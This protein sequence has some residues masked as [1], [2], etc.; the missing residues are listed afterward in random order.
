MTSKQYITIVLVIV[1]L[2]I[3]A[4]ACKKVEVIEPELQP[5]EQ[6]KF[7]PEP[8]EK[9]AVDKT[10]SKTIYSTNE[11]ISKIND[12]KGS[13]YVFRPYDLEWKEKSIKIGVWRHVW[14]YHYS[15]FNYSEMK[16]YKF[17]KS[18]FP[19]NFILINI[20]DPNKYLVSFKDVDTIVKEFGQGFLSYIDTEQFENLKWAFT[21]YEYEDKFYIDHFIEVED[22]GGTK[23]IRTVY[24]NLGIKESE[25]N[26]LFF[27]Q[28]VFIPCGKFNLI[29][30][31]PQSTQLYALELKLNRGEDLIKLQELG[32]RDYQKNFDTIKKITEFCSKALDKD[33]YSTSVESRHEKVIRTVPEKESEYNIAITLEKGIPKNASAMYRLI[34]DENVIYYRIENLGIT[35]QKGKAF[36]DNAVAEV[37]ITFEDGK[38]EIYTKE[39]DSPHFDVIE[40]YTK[41]PANKKVEKV[42]VGIYTKVSKDART[43]YAEVIK[44]FG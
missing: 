8:V 24:V 14:K 13:N 22:I 15:L 37:E 2:L 31:R 3:L 33:F 40:D 42:R 6:A 9:E 30:M 12:A 16:S 28:R 44:Q 17:L 21:P 11:I 7:E 4:L 36:L 26:D 19:E 43:T 35:E 18:D 5:A 38:T 20:V 34:R 29:M 32:N 39:P 23:I 27:Q 1:V 10:I 41:F 25:L